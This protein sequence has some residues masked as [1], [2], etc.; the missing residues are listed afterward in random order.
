VD[1]GKI[2]RI[3]GNVAGIFQVLPAEGRGPARRRWRL[4]TAYHVPELSLANGIGCSCADHLASSE[5]SRMIKSKSHARGIMGQSQQIRTY[6]GRGE[7]RSLA[8]ALVKLLELGGLRDGES[9]EIKSMAVALPD[10][11]MSGLV[12]VLGVARG[13]GPRWA[14]QMPPSA[15]FTARTTRGTRQT[16]EIGNLDGGE[17]D[18]DGNVQLADGQLLHCVD[19]IPAP[20][21]YEFTMWDHVVVYHALEF[22]QAKNECFLP[23]HAE[24]LPDVKR[25]D[26]SVIAQVRIKQWKLLQHY[27]G[28][29]IPGISPSAISAVLKRAGMKFPRSSA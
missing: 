26:Y 24:L 5:S 17:S 4:A 14:I 21:H 23:L 19:L 27:L 9:A 29:R 15:R 1:Q 28:Q 11:R 12:A 25:L 22:L 18:S 13:D 8:D 6:D 7:M 20:I 3:S 16:Y 10:G 2:K